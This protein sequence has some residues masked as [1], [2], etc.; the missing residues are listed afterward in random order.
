MKGLVGENELLY[1]QT[2]CYGD[3]HYFYTDAKLA[4]S[5]RSRKVGK[6]QAKQG[7]TIVNDSIHSVQRM[8]ATIK[9]KYL[10]AIAFKTV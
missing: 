6:Q 1:I 3:K 5:A 2:P 7:N 9:E 4:D 8:K 10:Y